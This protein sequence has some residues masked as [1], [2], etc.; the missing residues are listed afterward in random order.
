MDMILLPGGLEGIVQHGG[1]DGDLYWLGQLQCVGKFL[2]LPGE[3][4]ISSAT[5]PQ[6]SRV[7]RPCPV[8]IPTH[9]TPS[10]SDQPG[11]K[12]RHEERGGRGL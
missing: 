10:S 5:R 1:Y 11:Y 3:K 8:Q 4:A 6:R 2:V 12:N 7:G 9:T